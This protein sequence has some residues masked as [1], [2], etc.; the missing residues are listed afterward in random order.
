ME[1][2]HSPST[3]TIMVGVI[4]A[5]ILLSLLCRP[6]DPS[7]E[8]A[9]TTREAVEL[10]RDADTGLRS[11]VLWNSRL[12]LLAIVLGVSIPLVVAYLIWRASAQ[13]EIEVTEILDATEG[14]SLPGPRE[15][16]PESLPA[17]PQDSPSA[18]STGKPPADRQP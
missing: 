10:A 3:L 17:K 9:R 16:P 8:L 13:G 14:L 15:A 6:S 4:A 2:Q 12:R 18:G 11:A 1:E 7:A 5:V